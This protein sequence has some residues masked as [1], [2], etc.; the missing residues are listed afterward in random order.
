M[1]LP[2]TTCDSKGVGLFASDCCKWDI[3]RDLPELPGKFRDRQQ[4][5][6][7][8]V[9]SAPGSFEKSL[10]DYILC[11]RFLAPKYAYIHKDC[12]KMPSL[13]V[14]PSFPSAAFVHRTCH[15]EM[16][17]GSLPAMTGH[18]H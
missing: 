18:A 7:E 16:V 17:H 13:L 10:L 12:V 6:T 2:S 15:L 14:L 9:G 5:T 11:S 4:A 1:L 3:R 8:P